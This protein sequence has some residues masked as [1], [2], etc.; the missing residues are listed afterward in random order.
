MNRNAAYWL[1]VSILLVASAAFGS[2]ALARKAAV[3][4]PGVTVETGALVR[5]E[6]PVDGD[7]LLVKV[8]D[9]TATLRLVGVKTFDQ[10]ATKDA[11]SGYGREAV[12][13]INVIAQ[14]K[15]LR[16]LGN[17]P[18]KDKHGRIL[19]TLFVDDEDLGL[20]LV[21]RGVAMVYTAFPFPSMPSYLR[22]QEIARAERKGLWGD[23]AAVK[24]ADLLARQWREEAP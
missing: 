7:T 13:A 22:E 4:K 8:G 23:P 11:F 9:D 1:L 17:V 20:A 19:A 6:K 12:N 24:R 2:S 15:P 5:L 16:V 14:D 10:D 3:A 18:A 21:R